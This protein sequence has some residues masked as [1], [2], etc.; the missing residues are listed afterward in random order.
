MDPVPKIINIILKLKEVT[1]KVQNQKIL[2]IV[3]IEALFKGLQH[4]FNILKL[5]QMTR[6]VQMDQVFKNQ[7]ELFKE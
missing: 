5:K 1:R 2:K 4:Y 6:R 3:G 7:S